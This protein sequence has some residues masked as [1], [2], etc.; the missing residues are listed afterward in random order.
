M[1]PV[2]CDFEAN[3]IIYYVPGEEF[4]IT[5]I[6]GLGVNG[7]A[8]TVIDPLPQGVQVY[9]ADG[10]STVCLRGLIPEDFSDISG[11]LENGSFSFGL[12]LLTNSRIYM[13]RY[14]VKV[15]PEGASSGFPSG[16]PLVVGFDS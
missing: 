4:N 11:V 9:T 14:L 15:L 2:G 3:S 1:P 7:I 10:N 5:L 13:F 12:P 6:S 16:T 8:G